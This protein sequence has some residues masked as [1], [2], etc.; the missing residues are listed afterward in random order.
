L[1]LPAKEPMTPDPKAG[2]L[3]FWPQSVADPDLVADQ[4]RLLM[5]G[6]GYILINLLNAG[7]VSAVYWRFLPH[8]QNLAWLAAFCLVVLARLLLRR[9]YFAAA[10]GTGAAR[11]W[12]Q[13]YTLVA[14]AAGLLWGVTGLL[15]LLVPDPLDH[16]LIVFVLGGMMAGSIISFSA[17]RPAM[18]AFAV[19][20]I[21]P[22]ILALLSRGNQNDL[23]MGVML[24]GFAVVCAS[25]GARI[26]ASIAQNFQLR[27]AQGKLLAAEM[28]SAAALA[29]AQAIAHLGSWV[30]DH[31]SDSGAWSTE[32][33]R[34]L[35]IDPPIANPS[36][37]LFLAHV[38]ESD[39]ATVDSFYTGALG[40]SVDRAV[41]FR[42][43][44][45]DGTRLWVRA[46]G[47]TTFDSNGNAMRVSGTLQDVSEARRA[48]ELLAYR[49][50]LSFA[51]AECAGILISARALDEGMPH[52]LRVLGEV[53]GVDRFVMM[54]YEADP[55]APPRLCHLWQAPGI[56]VSIEGRALPQAWAVDRAAVLAWRVQLA[57][58]KIVDAQLAGS[59][60][61]LRA[62]L[63]RMHNQSTLLVPIF[64]GG[65][66]WG[67]LGVDACTV[68]KQWT[69][70]EHETLGLFADMAG[71]MIQ[72]DEARL[73]LQRS[74]SRIRQLN[75]TA[76]DA[77]ITIDGAGAIASW[78]SAAQRT[79]GYEASEVIG[80][81]VHEVMA[82]A[83]FRAVAD[84]AMHGFSQTGAG[85]ALGRTTELAARRKDGTEIAIELSLTGALVGSEWQA[86]GILR[87][88]STRKAAEHQI[89]YANLLLRTQMEASLDGILIVDASMRIT[90]FNRRLADIWK[91]P[92]ATLE[93][94]D[95]DAVLAAVAAAV[96]N[97][98]DFT[99][100]VRDLYAHPGQDSHDEFTLTDGRFVDRYTVTLYSPARLYLGRAWFFRDVTLRKKTEALALRMARFDV[101]TGLANRSVF[102]EA[103][104]HVI[105]VA[106][107]GGKGFAVIYL[108]LDHFKDV[109]DTLG[110]PVGDELLKAVADR[111]RASTRA[112][113]IVA[114]FGGDEF[115]VVA[116]DIENPA[117]AALLAEKL[118]GVIGGPYSLHGNDI[119]SG[120]SIGIAT[121]AADAADAETLLSHA[122][123]ALYRAKS[124][125]RGGYRFFTE[126]MDAE[127]QNR[128]TF[129]R[130][131]RVAVDAG[132]L[133]LMYQPQVADDTGRITGV[134]ALVRW[135]HPTR[136][137]LGPDLFIPIAE[138]VGAI[139]A[140]GSWVLRAACTQARAWRD[141]GIEPVRMCVNVSAL[142]L[143]IPL[144]FEATVAAVLAETGLE[145]RLLELEL[146]E[147]VFM[148]TVREHAEVLKRLR[149]SGITFAIDDF[150]TG[151]SSLD[152]LRRFRSN[153]LKIAQTFVS[154]LD[155]T[156]ENASIVKATIGLARDLGLGIIAE[157]V[158]TRQQL[159]LLKGWGC[160]EIQGFY[161][162]RPLSVADAT[163]ALR[164]GVIIPTDRIA[165]AG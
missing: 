40:D 83:R 100:R 155:T 111:L 32:M 69:V 48:A 59:E 77:I 121:Y 24:A 97:Q 3:A 4:I 133:F 71:S 85:A 139:I 137:V 89:E 42:I 72:R 106:Q 130:E 146:T 41:E 115:A 120:A 87:D 140:L 151:Y 46:T 30:Y 156:P 124:E 95:D 78:N 65:Q 6:G 8:W 129:G 20:T 1:T 127:V 136:G 91:I 16:V 18:M 29:E 163:V 10:P 134:E 31:H 25:A 47:R 23:A 145:P 158:E 152:Y 50:R 51:I 15:I 73:L 148:E 92:I 147:S 159:E 55:V 39:R 119:H 86:I 19:P 33:Y 2:R 165:Q 153:R 109:N 138:Q 45:A 112:T 118:I 79:L 62:L 34:I 67:N 107:R 142:Q 81:Q 38:E 7:I 157:G 135:R 70:T 28:L 110:H 122:D 98:E 101:V 35:G 27:I 99:E 102:V 113:D 76:Q 103:L 44:R 57:A 22:A 126:A 117:E 63:E 43:A 90:A 160:R 105:A 21:L 128:V 82:P 94:G 9:R 37:G 58:H 143:K 74:E 84:P 68:A 17:Y 12:G 64:I 26:N 36:H 5:Q 80:K 116:S 13:A 154:N 131:L 141:A 60:G 14:F 61:S 66:L 49:D 144:A 149:N 132:Q 52:A 114:R 164:V 75:E 123:V 162:S 93:K 104:K 54:H 108:D 56:A 53:L 11:R 161:Y 150:G 88:I 96:A 125:G